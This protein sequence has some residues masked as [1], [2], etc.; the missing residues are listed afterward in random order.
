MER[1]RSSLSGREH[2][3]TKLQTHIHTHMAY[4]EKE[5]NL[6]HRADQESLDY[7]L[8][9]HKLDITI[10]DV[11]KWMILREMNLIGGALSL[12]VISTVYN[13]LLI[14]FA[15]TK[16]VHQEFPF[17]SSDSAILLLEHIQGNNTGWHNDLTTYIFI[18]SFTQKMQ[19]IGENQMFNDRDWVKKL[20]LIYP[21]NSILKFDRKEYFNLEKCSQYIF[22]L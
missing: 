22:K 20:W 21:T 7:Q 3:N 6:V 15:Q 13:L 19:N 11:K 14:L 1:V 12:L 8:R 4:W 10:E 9:V 18:Y 17:N 2:G 5:S 16:T